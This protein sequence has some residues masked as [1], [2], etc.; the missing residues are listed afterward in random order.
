[1]ILKTFEEFVSSGV[2]KKQTPN[3]HR[4]LAIVKEVEGKWGFL[5][6]SLKAI[7]QEKMNPNFV[8]DSC[9]DM[10]MEL[11]RAKMFMDGYNA[12]N[13]HEAEISYLKKLGFSEFEIRFANEIRYYRNGTKYYGTLLDKEY[14]DKVMDFTNKIYPKLKGFVKI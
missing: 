5:E 11:I 13:S 12:G 4:A 2:V 10:L 3:V 9:Y 8:V 7:P 6:I 1:M 14:A